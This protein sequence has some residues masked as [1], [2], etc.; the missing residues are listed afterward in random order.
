M[1]KFDVFEWKVDNQTT[2]FRLEYKQEY[3]DWTGEL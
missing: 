2:S 3:I 1:C